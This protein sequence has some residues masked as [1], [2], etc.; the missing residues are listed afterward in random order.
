MKVMAA[1]AR[2]SLMRDRMSIIALNYT[3]YKSSSA[4]RMLRMSVCLNFLSSRSFLFHEPR[5]RL[6]SSSV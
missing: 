4:S 3:I 5:T 6:T 1:R 2:I